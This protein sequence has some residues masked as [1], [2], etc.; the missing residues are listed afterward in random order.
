MIRISRLIA[1]AAILTLGIAGIVSYGTHAGA[2]ANRPDPEGTMVSNGRDVKIIDGD[3]IQI[4]GQ[5]LDIA[6]IDA[7]ELGQQCQ[8]NGS[9]WDCGMSSAMQLRKYFAMAPFPVRCWPGHEDE[10]T[11]TRDIPIAECGIGDRDIGAAMVIDGEALPVPEYSHHY[12]QLSAEAANAEIG[13]HGGKIVP[14]ADWRNGTRLKGEENRCLYIED[15]NG[16]Y[17]SALD[18]AFEELAKAGHANICSD[19]EAREK[20]LSYFPASP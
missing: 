16:H 9:F 20:G 12:D 17:L 4:N 2:A 19:E 3:T 15:G 10:N 11:P 1:I 8:H 14:P 18:P 5:I 7:P 13:I 6:G